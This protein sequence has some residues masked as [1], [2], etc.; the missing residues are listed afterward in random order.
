M[1]T[2]DQ[3]TCLF[4]CLLNLS[5]GF[6]EGARYT[7]EYFT[8]QDASSE[9]ISFFRGLFEDVK[10]RY[11]WPFYFVNSLTAV[12]NLE[13][14]KWEVT[15]EQISSSR[16]LFR[17]ITHI[18][19]TGF[20]TVEHVPFDETQTDVVQSKYDEWIY[21]FVHNTLEEELLEPI[22]CVPK[23]SQ[24]PPQQ[25]EFSQSGLVKLFM[26][27]SLTDPAEDP[28]TTNCSV[29]DIVNLHGRREELTQSHKN[30]L[31]FLF[32]L[33][34]K[35]VDQKIHYSVIKEITTTTLDGDDF[36]ATQKKSELN[37]I[38]ISLADAKFIIY[39]FVE[40]SKAFM[41]LPAD[42][43]NTNLLLVSHLMIRL[44]IPIS[45]IGGYNAEAQKLL[46]PEVLDTVVRLLEFVRQKYYLPPVEIHA[47]ASFELNTNIIRLVGNI[48]HVN[49]PA[50]DHLLQ[51]DLMKP[52]V[53]YMAPDKNNPLSRESTIVFLRYMSES[54]P[55]AADYIQSLKVYDLYEG[56]NKFYSKMDFI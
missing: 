30:M 47:D 4:K 34:Q 33:L 8:K 3:R 13:Q 19:I 12:K 36:Y 37:G 46:F 41:Q 1:W 38:R 42:T 31:T 10:L 20:F 51:H 6:P 27:L 32:T 29:A 43:K 45:F 5:T 52:L 40:C 25:Q 53:C 50:Q 35:T 23:D 54:N 55:A 14:H 17:I 11:L 18:C 16:S 15:W 49:K 9:E 24:L 44:L 7:L 21:L 22:L 56:K 28:A 39:T 26:L 2:D 48:V